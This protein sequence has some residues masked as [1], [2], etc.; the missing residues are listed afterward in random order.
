MLDPSHQFTTPVGVTITLALCIK[1]MIFQIF[2]KGYKHQTTED[3]CE[4]VTFWDTLP[5]QNFYIASLHHKHLSVTVG[6]EGKSGILHTDL[7]HMPYNVGAVNLIEYIACV[8][9]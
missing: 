3:C 8:D 2:Y 9:Y 1:H 5:Y 4:R 6:V 7:L